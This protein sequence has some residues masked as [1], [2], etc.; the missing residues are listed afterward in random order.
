[1]KKRIIQLAITGILK[2]ITLIIIAFTVSW[3]VKK[4]GI[5][6][7]FM[8]WAGITITDRIFKIEWRD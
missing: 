5:E 7:V 6:P 3:A 4:W 2:L 8:F 1:M